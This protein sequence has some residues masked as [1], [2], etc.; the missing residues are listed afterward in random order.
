MIV[1]NLSLAATSPD[2]NFDR[3]P[4]ECSTG[5]GDI[6]GDDDVDAEDVRLFVDCL[7]TGTCFCP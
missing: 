1:R 2:D 7:L 5:G 4:D 3:V 6:D